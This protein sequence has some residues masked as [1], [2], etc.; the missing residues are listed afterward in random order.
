MNELSII[1]L[2]EDNPDDAELIQYAFEKADIRNPLVIVTDGD[3]AVDYI[4]RTGAYADRSGL[5]L[6]E[7]ILLDL[8]LPRRSGLEVLSFIRQH[9]PTRHTPVVVLTSSD[10]EAD[11]R[12]SYERGANSF[13]VKPIG[14]DG[15]I[16]MARALKAYWIKLNHGVAL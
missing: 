16:D 2:V 12:R 5:P 4:G 14:R 7:L 6:P 1:L 8:K 10:Q 9:E 3:A 13:L 11:I 15:L